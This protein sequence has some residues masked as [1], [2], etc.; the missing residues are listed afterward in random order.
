M[1]SEENQRVRSYLSQLD[2]SISTALVDDIVTVVN[3]QYAD[4]ILEPTPATAGY[5]ELDNQ[6]VIIVIQSMYI[7]SL[8]N[9]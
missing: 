3:R 9:I 7:L 5:T 1:S 4:I 8:L 6:V 2:S